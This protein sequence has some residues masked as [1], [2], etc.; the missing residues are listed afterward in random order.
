MPGKA[1]VFAHGLS[2]RPDLRLMLMS[3]TAMLDPVVKQI[4]QEQR[5]EPFA[6]K[7]L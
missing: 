6:R 3:A 4:V 7:K 2:R 1:N 5:K